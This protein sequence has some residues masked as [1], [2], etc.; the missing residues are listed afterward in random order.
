MCTFVCF[1]DHDMVQEDI[2]RYLILIL[3]YKFQNPN[4]SNLHMQ[5]T[6][7]P[8]LQVFFQDG[9]NNQ[10]DFYFY[11]NKNYALGLHSQQSTRILLIEK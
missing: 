8:V 4:E 11:G 7:V 1:Y 5:T 6:V 2:L 9:S 10:L 3:F